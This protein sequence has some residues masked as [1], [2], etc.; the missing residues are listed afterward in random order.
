[1]KPRERRAALFR[2]R[3]GDLANA[4]LDH[5]YGF[6]LQRVGM[7]AILYSAITISILA[8]LVFMYLLYKNKSTNSYSLVFCL[9]NI[10]SS[11]LWMYYSIQQEDHRL[12]VR[13]S[14]EVGLLLVSSVYIVRNKV[15]LVTRSTV[16]PQ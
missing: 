16:L 4:A 12:L 10:G 2:V 8:R 11:G 9:M 15:K 7:D 6:R 13:S 14:S 5:G 1:V 3:N